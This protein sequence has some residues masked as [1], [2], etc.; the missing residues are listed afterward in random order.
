MILITG[1][2][3]GIGKYLFDK[4]EQ[5]GE[6]VFGTYYQSNPPAGKEENYSKVDIRDVNSIEDWLNNIDDLNNIT[7]INCAGNNYAAFAHKSDNDK[8][9]EVIDVNL[10]G[11]FNVISKVLPLMREQNFGRIINFSSVVAQVHTP[12]ASSYAAS[13]SG[14]WGMVKSI[15]V[16]NTKYNITIN[17]LNLGYYNIGMITEVTEEYQK[18]I[19]EK[20]PTHEFGEPENIHKAVRFLIDSD[21]TNGTSL[22]INGGLF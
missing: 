15:A 22:D 8:W 11:T 2:S 17:N 19:K 20:I 9:K 12:G 21:Y 6:K 18:K 4:F 16:E 10:T 7:L 5:E 14:L 3:R 1:A 13:K